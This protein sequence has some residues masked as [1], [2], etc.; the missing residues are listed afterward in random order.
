M[1]D[2]NFPKIKDRG[3]KSKMSQKWKKKKAIESV[4]QLC[5]TNKLRI[6]ETNSPDKHGWSSNKNSLN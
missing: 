2:T 4:I 3:G 6:G 1:K 5:K